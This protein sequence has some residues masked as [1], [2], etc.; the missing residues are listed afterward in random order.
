MKYEIRIKIDDRDVACYSIEANSETEAIQ[1]CKNNHQAKHYAY[2][3]INK[4]RTNNEQNTN[5][6]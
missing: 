4:L 5:F 1:R 6:I 2:K 3:N